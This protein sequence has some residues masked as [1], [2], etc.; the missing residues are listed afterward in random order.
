M[1]GRVRAPGFMQSLVSIAAPPRCG[2]CGGGCAPADPLCARCDAE[3]RGARGSVAAGLPGID[4]A[5]SA[6]AYEGVPRLIAHGLKY[7]RR[8][9]LAAVAARAMLRACP[10]G[11]LGGVVVPV[12]AAP[13]RG[14]WRGFDPAEEIS[15]AMAG[16]AGLEY[17]PCLRR[18][19]GPKQVG[20]P[21]RE[22]L[23]DPP[24]IGLRRG[25]AAPGSVLLI[26]DVRTTGATLRACA[27]ALR[28]GGAERIVAVAFAHSRRTG[29]FS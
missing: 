27:G 11:E 29:S 18:G 23:S 22:R 26:D 7:G 4:L 17:R 12:P 19:R 21:R 24:R 1:V 8:T 15:L 16:E 3:I 2:A 20:R 28:A 6:A 5:V 10:A 14:R 13:W 9:S 25:A